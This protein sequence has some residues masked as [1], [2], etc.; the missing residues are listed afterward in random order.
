[1]AKRDHPAEMDKT[2]SQD[3]LVP[4]D[5][6]EERVIP[7]IPVQLA[8]PVI[9]A[10]PDY[11]FTHSVPFS[12]SQITCWVQATMHQM[13]FGRLTPDALLGIR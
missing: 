8:D 6:K 9:P 2:V 5:Q 3:Q 12:R 11:R 4:K 1:V 13:R 10:F 7:V